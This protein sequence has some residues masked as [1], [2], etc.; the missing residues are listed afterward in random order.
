MAH[1]ATTA[2]TRR[3]TVLRFRVFPDCWWVRSI[4]TS[5]LPATNTKG[6]RIV[7]RTHSGDRKI[8]DSEFTFES[9]TYH[10]HFAK[11]MAKLHNWKWSRIFTGGTQRGYCHLFML[12]VRSNK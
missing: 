7:A 12:P 3:S 5:R 11:E 1:I 8:F 9:E 2:A 4:E 10:L 6:A